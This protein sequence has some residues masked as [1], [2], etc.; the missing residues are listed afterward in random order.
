MFKKKICIS[1]I[2]K[3]GDLILTLPV[4]KSVKIQN[5]NSEIHILA[6]TYNAKVLKNI[7]YIDKILLIG[8]KPHSIIKEIRQLR[9]IQYDFFINFSPNIKSFILCFFSKSQ[10]KAALI[11]LSRYKNNFFSKV[12]L[13]IFSRIFCHFQYVVNR[14][15]R[16]S[17]N[18]ELHQ[19]KMM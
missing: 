4:I 7:K 3:I 15:E 12:F 16:L 14:F 17:N 11:L 19:T 13:R 2:D 10:K 18:Q 9:K 6:S 5:P 1:R 8:S